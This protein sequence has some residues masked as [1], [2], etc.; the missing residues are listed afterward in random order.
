MIPALRY[1]LQL[2]H[3]LRWRTVKTY[4]PG[5]EEFRVLDRV[6]FLLAGKAKKPARLLLM[7]FNVLAVAS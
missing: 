1:T 2:R 4:R 7:P 6:V 5:D 3:G